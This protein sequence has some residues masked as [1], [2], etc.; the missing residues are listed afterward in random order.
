M[1]IARLKKVSLCG[2]LKEKQAVLEALQSLG[3]MHLLPL[4]PPPP[5]VENIASPRAE[6]AYKA[7]RFLSDV[8][9]K[10]RQIVRDPGFDVDRLVGEALDLQQQLRNATDRRDF[11]VHRIAAV[12][13]WGD[14]IFPPHEALSGYRLWFYILPLGDLGALESVELP[15]Q[16]LRKDHRV[17]YVVLISPDEPESNLLPV[18][19]THT[20]ALPL[21]ELRAQLEDVEVAV[22]DLVARRQALTRYIYLLSVNLAEAENRASLTHAEQQTRDD[23]A[24]VAVQGWVPV[25]A[26]AAVEAYAKDAKLACLIEEPGPKDAPP[27]LI[28]QPED[29]SAGVDLTLF[30]QVPNYRAWDP[31]LLLVG[32]FSLFFA[33]ILADAG[34]G[35]LLLAGLAAF[36]G[37]L[38]RSPKGRA[39][40]RLGL[41]LFGC[42]VVYGVLV[43]SYFG[44]SPPA[45]SL[46]ERLHI[47]SVDDFE[48]MMRLSIVIGVLH[49]VLAN[50]IMA[51]VLR[52]RLVALSK[53]GWI[54]GLCGGLLL[55]LAEPGS[56]W[57][58]VSH[59]LLA[60]GL[61][62][63]FLFSSE[64]P[65][66]T[67]KDHLG[68]LL[69]GLK[70]LTG[71]M[72]AFGDVLSYMRLFALGLASASLAVTF[73]DLARGVH[74][75][76]PGVGLLLAILLL[77]VGHTLN[78]GLSLMSGVVHGLR[79]N[80]IEFYKWGLPEEGESFRK[81]ARKEVKP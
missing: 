1:S 71:V 15:W 9:V 46:P 40:R 14:L 56:I 52:T 8:P 27:T 53:L 29:L 54:A 65:A 21:A 33:M 22:E 18:P 45:G 20:G 38:S 60:G 57:E 66:R 28:E 78:L 31:T 43:G 49:I 23:D 74:E 35:L 47:L 37:R 44:L 24:V 58:T 59:T 26:V 4:R 64:R 3:C 68:R 75:A 72:G 77:L 36:W 42:T 55:W 39:Y 70:G 73:N 69:D 63:V 11:L 41:S 81:F 76:L 80:F 19:R 10:R 79:L 61:F 50:A 30:Y 32:S 16:I 6:G 34:Y 51:Y 25:D 48:T 67:A 5:E 12:E 13:P 2:L 17:A 62:A 7:L